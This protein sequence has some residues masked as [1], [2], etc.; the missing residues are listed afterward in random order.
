MEYFPTISGDYDAALK[1]FRSR[2]RLR[3][4]YEDIVPF[5]IAELNY[6]KGHKE[7]ALKQA[8]AIYSRYENAPYYEAMSQLA[9]Q[10]Y[11]E[12]ND[13]RK[14]T[15]VSECTYTQQEE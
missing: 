13:F 9:G 2:K 5:Y 3:K 15:G 8:L 12:K 14:G 4:Q 10:I 1:E 11:Y 6:F 7:S